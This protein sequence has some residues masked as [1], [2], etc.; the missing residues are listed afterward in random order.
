MPIYTVVKLKVEP[1]SDP[2]LE[3]SNLTLKCDSQ[4]LKRRDPP[5]DPV[6]WSVVFSD[7]TSRIE[8]ILTPTNS[9]VLPTGIYNLI[10]TDCFL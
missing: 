2:L 4:K 9:V 1:P 6:E 5:F 3:G 7:S 8:T 10:L